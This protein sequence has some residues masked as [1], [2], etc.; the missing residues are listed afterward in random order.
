MCFIYDITAS[1]RDPLLS[2]Q[3]PYGNSSI[4]FLLV[5]DR[6]S[7]MIS[8]LELADLTVRLS[9]LFQILSIWISIEKRNFYKFRCRSYYWGG[10][11][12]PVPFAMVFFLLAD[13][14][15]NEVTCCAHHAPNRCEYKRSSKTQS[16]CCV[17]VKGQQE[18]QEYA[19]SIFSAASSL[20]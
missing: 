1:I 5:S 16:Q 15:W 3:D 17:A 12:F 14:G 20:S 6:L 4:S 8:Y 19:L 7:L 13:S 2:W 11:P 18:V 10:V 9:A